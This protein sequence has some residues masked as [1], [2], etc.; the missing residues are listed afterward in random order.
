MTR[1][2]PSA[3]SGSREQAQ[4]LVIGLA[5]DLTGQSILLDCTELT[6]SSP[7]F[8]DEVVKQVLV[9]R[10]ATV[11][12]AHAASER[13]RTLVERAAANRNVKDRLRV[14]PRAA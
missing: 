1:L 11:L 4:E 2:V 8:L 12:D 13:T 9:L 6:V 14:T 10:N 3:H 5:P 7:S